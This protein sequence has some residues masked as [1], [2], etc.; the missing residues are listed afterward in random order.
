MADPIDP[1]SYGDRQGERR[2]GD[3]RIILE[4]RHNFPGSGRVTRRIEQTVT[5]TLLIVGLVL[6][7][8]IGAGLLFFGIT[9]L[10]WH[11]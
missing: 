6:G 7:M 9:R 2:G 11:L 5:W 1:P 4:R 3:R 8:A 10:H